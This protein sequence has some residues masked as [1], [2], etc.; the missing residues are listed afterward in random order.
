MSQPTKARVSSPG[1]FM[2]F[3]RGALSLCRQTVH[4]DRNNFYREVSNHAAGITA[5]RDAA[6]GLPGRKL[7]S[8]HQAL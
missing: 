4:R 3:Y 2:L 8:A 1:A 6:I 7:S 5:R